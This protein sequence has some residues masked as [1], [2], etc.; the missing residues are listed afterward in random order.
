MNEMVSAPA[1]PDAPEV[2]TE[3][4]VTKRD[5]LHRAADLL[6]EFGWCQFSFGQT[7]NGDPALAGGREAVRFCALGAMGRACRDLGLDYGDR[8]KFYGSRG[9]GWMRFNDTY[10]RTAQEVVAALR[11]EA[12]RS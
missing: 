6:E 7:E 4:E 2:P 8:C 12:E 11:E 5:V 1:L 3:R 9:V 10:G